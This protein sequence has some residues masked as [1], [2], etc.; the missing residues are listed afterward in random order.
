MIDLRS[1]AIPGSGRE[2]SGAGRKQK[3]ITK[4]YKRKE[5]IEEESQNEEENVEEE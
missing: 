4:E 2:W 5:Q 3:M 1:S